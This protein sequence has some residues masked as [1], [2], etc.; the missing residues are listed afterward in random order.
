MRI[1]KL[2]YEILLD[3]LSVIDNSDIYLTGDNDNSN[4]LS[5]KIDNMALQLRRLSTVINQF[6][7]ILSANGYQFVTSN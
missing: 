2:I 4:Y 7:D 1:M 6:G 5:I 3:Y